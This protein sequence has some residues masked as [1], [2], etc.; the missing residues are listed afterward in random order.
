[1]K[2][3]N[4]PIIIEFRFKFPKYVLTLQQTKYG[5][6]NDVGTNNDKVENN[7]SVHDLVCSDNLITNDQQVRIMF[8]N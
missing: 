7:E 2:C 6:N 1:M 4:I 5:E 8:E 3:I